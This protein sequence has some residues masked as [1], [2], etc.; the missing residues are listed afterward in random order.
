MTKRQEAKRVEL[1]ARFTKQG[2]MTVANLIEL[3]KTYPQGAPVTSYQGQEETDLVTP[4]G[5]RLTN[6]ENTA[7][8]LSVFN[9]HAHARVRGPFLDIMGF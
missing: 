3:L 9:T 8:H 1:Q 4:A 2:Y 6:D 5:V 7:Y